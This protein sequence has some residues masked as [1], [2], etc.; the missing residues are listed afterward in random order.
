MQKSGNGHKMLELAQMCAK[1]VHIPQDIKCCGFAGS[2]GFLVPEL[3]KNALKT[4]K[5]QIPMAC[6]EGYSCSQ[7]CEIGLTKHSGVPYRSLLYLLGEA[8]LFTSQL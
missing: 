6:T 4:L 8:I 3:N 7:T 1:K 2:K 5:A